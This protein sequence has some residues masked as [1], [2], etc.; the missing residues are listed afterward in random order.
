MDSTIAL[1]ALNQYRKR[2]VLPYLGLRY[3]LDNKS[4]RSQ[5]WFEEVATK[6]A[7]DNINSPYIR[8]FHFKER[9]PSGEYTHRDV[10]LPSPNEA[11]AE[12]VLITELSKHTNFQ[13]KPYV[14]SYRLSDHNDTSGVFIPYFN[15]LKD[16]QRDIAEACRVKTDGVV[17]Y[18]DIKRFYPSINSHDAQSVWSRAAAHAGLRREHV[19]LGEAFLRKHHDKCLKDGSGKGLLTGPVFSHIIANL[20]LDEVDSFMHDLTEGHYWRYVDDIVLVGAEADVDQWRESLQQKLNKY[21]LLL[22]DGAKD[23][24]VD[25]EAW[26]DGEKDFET[27]ISNQWISL[28]ADTKRYL[29]K[30]PS[31]HAFQ[32]LQQHFRQKDIRIPL[33]DYS[34]AAKEVTTLLSFSRWLKRYRTW[35]YKNIKRITPEHLAILAYNTR[36]ELMNQ[37]DKLLHMHNRSDVYANKRLIPKLRF[38]AGRLVLL[39]SRV[40]LSEVSD[41]L[42]TFPELSFLCTIMDCV[43]SRDV[44]EVL[45]MGANATQAACQVLNS[46]PEPVSFNIEHY[47]EI[48]ELSLAVLALNGIDFEVPNTSSKLRQFALGQELSGLMTDDDTFIKEISCLHGNT[49]PRH[50]SM[51]KQAFDVDEDLALDVINQL[52]NSSHC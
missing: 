17:L 29:I 16:R 7:T 15:G 10:Y 12:I 6:L 52:Q 3:Y 35:S 42:R 44:S 1:K 11:L 22:H 18:T 14:Y 23:F 26:L 27:D 34:I 28:I 21:E 39:A 32:V 41:R 33:I 51:L 19:E 45:K 24:K 25:S 5:R 30:N 46:S 40:E 2:D 4:A 13:P 43:A 47:D 20:L 50:E 48:V 37:I 38:I 31:E 36:T 8:T 49:A 9:E